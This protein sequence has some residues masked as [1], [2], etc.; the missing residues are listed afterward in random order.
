MAIK[1]LLSPG[2]VSI[3]PRGL[4]MPLKNTSMEEETWQYFL[5]TAFSGVS[6]LMKITLLWSVVST[7]KACRAA[8]R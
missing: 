4:M 3:G 8:V 7:Q 6:A 2:T 1:L 5:A